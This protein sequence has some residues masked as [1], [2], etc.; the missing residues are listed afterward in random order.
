MRELFN[1]SEDISNDVIEKQLNSILNEKGIKANIDEN[2]KDAI[3][4]SPIEGIF[5]I[6]SPEYTTTK[7]LEI[8]ACKT[9]VYP[10]LDMIDSKCKDLSLD[11]DTIKK[12][13][14]LA[15]DYLKKTYRKPHYS[16]IKPVIASL[17]KC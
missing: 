13:R 4:F 2:N 6:I 5:K 11:E 1:I 16:N 17:I 3:S 12:T 8:K 14:E 9:F 15:I 7:D 10:N